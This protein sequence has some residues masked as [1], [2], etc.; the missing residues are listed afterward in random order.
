MLTSGLGITLLD[1]PS[2]TLP[3]SVWSHECRAGTV[4]STSVSANLRVQPLHSGPSLFRD[5][6]RVFFHK[7]LVDQLQRARE[8]TWR[9][10][11]DNSNSAAADCRP[12]T[13]AS[14]QLT[15]FYLYFS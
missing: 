10:T 7:R 9:I 2:C 14:D 6:K 1:P 13:S 11:R 8:P 4:R 5:T 15:R 12:V 3:R